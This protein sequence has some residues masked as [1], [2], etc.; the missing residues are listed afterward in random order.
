[1]QERVGCKVM[2]AGAAK[3]FILED[4]VDAREAITLA[5]SQALSIDS[6]QA[7]TFDEMMIQEEKVLSCTLAILDI[8]LGSK[9]RSGIDAYQWL[10]KHRF[11]GDIVFLT[12]HASEHPLVR[13]ARSIGEAKVLSKPVTLE[14]LRLLFK[15]RA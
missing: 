5:L 8:N 1:V 11:R 2:N 6:V 10:R 4:D 7:G 13:E 3:V 14:R 15:D 12:G 9:R